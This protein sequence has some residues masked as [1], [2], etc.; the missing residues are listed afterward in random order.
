MP[1]RLHRYYGAGPVLVNEAEKI[2]L[3]VRKVS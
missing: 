2:V 1:N 3:R